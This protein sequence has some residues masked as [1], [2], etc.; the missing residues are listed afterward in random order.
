MR[1]RKIGKSGNT[2]KTVQVELL[3]ILSGRKKEKE[4]TAA[5]A[6]EANRQRAS[7]KRFPVKIRAENQPMK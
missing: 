7:Q 6:K 3:T 4:R 1:G 5:R 2:S